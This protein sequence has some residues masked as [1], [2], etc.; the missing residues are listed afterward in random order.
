MA[1]VRDL[2]PGDR[3]AVG[4]TSGI[5]ITRAAH[6]RY[7]GLQLVVWRMDSGELSY[8]ALSEAQEVGDV[9]IG[10]DRMAN[11]REALEPPHEPDII[12]DRSLLRGDINISREDPS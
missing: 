8:D 6:P 9:L 5:Y 4:P 3:V 11:L 10:E 2:I 7:V 1:R 12:T